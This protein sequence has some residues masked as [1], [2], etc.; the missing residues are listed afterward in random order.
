[1]PC[2]ELDCLKQSSFAWRLASQSRTRWNP[3]PPELQFAGQRRGNGFERF[4]FGVDADDGFDDGA[5]NHQGGPDEIA[6]DQRGLRP[7]ADDPAE[8]DRRADSAGESSEGVEDRDGEGSNLER[9][10]F[11]SRSNRRRGLTEKHEP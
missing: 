9:G 10:K 6:D 7:G 5:E 8:E 3:A 11:R 4:A 2:S 1:M